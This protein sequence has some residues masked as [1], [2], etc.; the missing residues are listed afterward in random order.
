MGQR[1][2]TYFWTGEGW[3]YLAVITGLFSRRV[4]GSAMSER[5]TAGL[6]REDLQLDSSRKWQSV[7]L[8]ERLDGHQSFWS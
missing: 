3:L 8:E 7:Q 4:V 2:I 1:D 5:M 6:V